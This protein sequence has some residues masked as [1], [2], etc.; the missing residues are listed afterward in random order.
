MRLS[1]T[2]WDPVTAPK[3]ELGVGAGQQ[4]HELGKQAEE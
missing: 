4:P 2:T 1:D 3:T